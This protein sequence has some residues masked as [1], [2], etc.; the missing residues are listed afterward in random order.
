MECRQTTAIGA[1]IV[2]KRGAI[3]NFGAISSFADA[4]QDE[5]CACACVCDDEESA[6]FL[7]IQVLRTEEPKE[8]I[9]PSPLFFHLSLLSPRPP[10]LTN[11][12]PHLHMSK[13]E[14]PKQ[15]SVQY[16][17]ILWLITGHL[18]KQAWPR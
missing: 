9:P 2:N 1:L 6:C 8:E 5:L 13:A 11:A 12:Q 3:T 7:Q 16:K 4:E 17:V 15:T 10:S 18:F 14:M